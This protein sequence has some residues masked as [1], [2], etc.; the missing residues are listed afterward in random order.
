MEQVSMQGSIAIVTGAAGGIGAATA[1][2]LAALGATVLLTDTQQTEGVKVAVAIGDNAHFMMHDVSRSGEWENVVRVAE[3][4]FGPV[5]ILINNAGTTAPI[6]P[7]DQVS[8]ADYRRVVE[9]NQLSCFLGMKAVVPSMRRAGAGAI[10]NISSVAGLQPERGAIAYVASKYAVTGMTKVAALD[11]AALSIRVNSVHP[12][13]VDT[14]MV[15]PRGDDQAFET[16]AQFAK[17]LPIPR[18]GRP[19]EIA[20]LIVFL[21]SDAAS[22]LTGGSYAAD[23]GWTL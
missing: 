3:D 21:A 8:E 11:L 4:R 2:S 14:P 1:R 15:R 6:M 7:L 13:L 22:F 10:V 19:E 12:G 20:S 5:S 17:G 16:I 18:P 9:I 23:G